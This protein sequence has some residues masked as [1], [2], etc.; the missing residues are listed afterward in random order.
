[1]VAIT[2]PSGS[3]K[4]TLMHILGCLDRPDEGRY[5]LA[6]EDVSRMSRDRL[7]E[8]RNRRIGFVFQ[9]FNLLPRM[10]AL[11]NV[12]LPLLYAGRTD[13]REIARAALERVGLGDRL[14]HEPNQLSGGQRQRVAIAR[15]LVTDPALL[16]ADEP[17]GNLDSRTG[18]EILALF[19]ALNREGHTIVIVTHDPAIAAFCDR[20][21]RLRDG[22][23]S[24]DITPVRPPRRPRTPPRHPRGLELR[25]S[26]GRSSRSASRAC[27]RTSCAR[28]WR[29]SASSSASAR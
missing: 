8:V 11:E 21:V 14:R 20:Q 7:A 4:S 24:E 23:V 1:M 16:L 17:T 25:C 9:T 18:E 26:T 28:S 3:G 6:G 13:T 10:S 27:S 15:A 22:R 19:K 29:C 12:E 2:G 5:L